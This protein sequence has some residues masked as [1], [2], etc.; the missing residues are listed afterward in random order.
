MEGQGL[1]T[2]VANRDK[3]VKGQPLTLTLLPPR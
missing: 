3:E 2:Y 1:F